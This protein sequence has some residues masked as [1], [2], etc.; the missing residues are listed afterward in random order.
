MITS[1]T[2]PRR[3]SLRLISFKLYLDCWFGALHTLAHIFTDTSV[4]FRSKPSHRFENNE[5]Q[6]KVI[7]LGCP[8]SFNHAE[9]TILNPL[10]LRCRCASC[11]ILVI[12]QQKASNQHSP[13]P[14]YARLR[15][16]F[17]NIVRRNIQDTLIRFHL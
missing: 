13:I 8:I 1:V 3:C 2:P 17:H 10:Q 6:A 12:Y 16:K 14:H 4:R 5:K 15:T 7:K 11:G 9:Q